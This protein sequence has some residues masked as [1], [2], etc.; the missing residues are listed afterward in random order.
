MLI[1]SFAVHYF[2]V[3][4]YGI[5]HRDISVNNIL[6]YT[7]GVRWPAASADQQK[8]EDVIEDKKFPR[9]LLIDYDYADL[10]NAENQGVSNGHRTVRFSVGFV[11][12]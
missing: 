5:L 4:V 12:L 8:R 9:G 2:L 6:R 3:D 1:I 11:V 7:C 10:L